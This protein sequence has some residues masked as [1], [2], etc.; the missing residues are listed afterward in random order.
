VIE[1]DG[2]I[3]QSNI[4]EVV[5]AGASIVVAGHAIFGTPD[6]EAATRSLRAA[7]AR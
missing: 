6:A 2:G 7:A 4:A 5:T 1:I 3:D